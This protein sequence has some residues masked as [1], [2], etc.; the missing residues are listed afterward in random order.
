MMAAGDEW[1]RA[2]TA[3]VRWVAERLQVAHDLV[4]ERGTALD[5]G[6]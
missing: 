4:R 6:A 3:R 2:P 5:A 1:V